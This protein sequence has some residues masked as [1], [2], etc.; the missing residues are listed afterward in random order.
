M[1]NRTVLAFIFKIFNN[2]KA[3]AKI[4]QMGQLEVYTIEDMELVS[5][6]TGFLL[7]YNAEE[8]EATTESVSPYIYSLNVVTKKRS[9]VVSA[10]LPAGDVID[11]MHTTHNFL[12]LSTTMFISIERPIDDKIMWQDPFL[13]E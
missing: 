11:A 1:K 10:L 2:T 7:T 8:A 5:I 3:F 6:I 9:K 4:T 13:N 12:N